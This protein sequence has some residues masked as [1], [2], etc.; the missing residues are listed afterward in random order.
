M[1]SMVL[2]EA[3]MFQETPGTHSIS[4]KTVRKE[5]SCQEEPFLILPWARKRVADVLLLREP[6]LCILHPSALSCYT[7]FSHDLYHV[8]SL[9]WTAPCQHEPNLAGLDDGGTLPNPLDVH[10]CWSSVRSRYF[11]FN[12]IYFTRIRE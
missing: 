10:R 7:L 3:N 5:I 8:L 2:T 6:S 9:Q 11:S 1:I 4:E 12:V